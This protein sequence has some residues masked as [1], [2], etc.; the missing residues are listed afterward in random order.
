[1]EG[2]N[3]MK[4][5]LTLI[6][7][8]TLL[9]AFAGGTGGGGVVGNDMVAIIRNGQTI[10]VPKLDGFKDKINLPKQIV[11]QK[12]ANNEIVKFAYGKLEN[13]QWVIEDIKQPFLDLDPEVLS[14]LELSRETKQWVELK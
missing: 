2:I 12:N 5:F 11:F 9:S 3:N 4:L 1:M 10:L 13:K 7:T 8:F 6:S 14:A